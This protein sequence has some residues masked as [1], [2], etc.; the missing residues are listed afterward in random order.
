MTPMWIIEGSR[1]KRDFAERRL[2]ALAHAVRQ[3]EDTGRAHI[4]QG[5]RPH[6]DRLYKRLRE[7][8]GE[9]LER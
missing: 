4:T 3:H 7:L 6:D 2:A 1:A 5:A 8:C 9:R